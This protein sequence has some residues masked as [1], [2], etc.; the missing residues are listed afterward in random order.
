MGPFGSYP[1]LFADDLL[2]ERF[3]ETVFCRGR[4]SASLP[5]RGLVLVPGLGMDSFAWRDADAFSFEH[6]DRRIPFTAPFERANITDW[7]DD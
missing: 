7:R 3:W 1:Q 6:D 5:G 2:A 4:C